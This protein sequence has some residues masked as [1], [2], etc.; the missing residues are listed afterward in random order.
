MTRPSR[1]PLVT[2]AGLCDLQSAK[3]QLVD[4]AAGKMR[5]RLVRATVAAAI[6][7]ARKEAAPADVLPRRVLVLVRQS[8][9]AL[10]QQPWKADTALLLKKRLD[11]GDP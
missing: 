4:A 1:R 9:K 7:L 2:A 3:Q 10:S 6:Q 11:G 5:E 8:L